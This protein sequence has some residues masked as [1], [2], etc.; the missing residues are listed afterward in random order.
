MNT[1]VPAINIRKA[2]MLNIN[3]DVIKKSA[4]KTS[5][6][7][8][9]RLNRAVK[10]NIPA[11]RLSSR[12]MMAPLQVNVNVNMSHTYNIQGPNK[13]AIGHTEALPAYFNDLNAAVLA[14]RDAYGALHSKLSVSQ[15]RDVEL[16]LNRNLSL[17]P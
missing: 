17:P 4:L 6:K 3:P 15:Q 7:N 2:A 16:S 5:L 13:G 8:D 11:P 12:N 1:K 10:I 14:G 9:G